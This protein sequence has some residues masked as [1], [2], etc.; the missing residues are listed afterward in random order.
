MLENVTLAPLAGRKRTLGPFFFGVASIRWPGYEPAATETTVP[1]RETVYARSR[2]RQGRLYVHGFESEPDMLT[3]RVAPGAA[4]A[5]P[6]QPNAA[7]T[8]RAS[9]NVS[10]RRL[11]PRVGRAETIGAR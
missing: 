5:V 4:A 6:P 8:A 7:R 1:G 2:L 10:G 3:K 11:F 9:A